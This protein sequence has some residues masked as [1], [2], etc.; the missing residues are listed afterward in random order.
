MI[1]GALLILVLTLAKI[2]INISILACSFVYPLWK[3]LRTLPEPQNT[4][5]RKVLIYWLVLAVILVADK[6]ISLLLIVLPFYP[7]SKLA[8]YCGLWVYDFKVSLIVFDF[9]L[10]NYMEILKMIK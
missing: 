10:Y 1:L 4:T 3:T 5:H 6:P 7:H 8:L 9:G 2:F